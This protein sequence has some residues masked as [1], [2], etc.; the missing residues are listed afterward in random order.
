MKLG[1]PDVVVGTPVYEDLAKDEVFV[2][3][4]FNYDMNAASDATGLE[5][6]DPSLAV[7]S[8][9]EE[10]DINTIVR[11]FNL[12]GQLPQNVVMPQYGDFEGVFDFQ[13]AMNLLIDAEKSFMRFPAEVRK[14]FDNDPAK[15]VDFVSDERNRDE[16]RKLGFL[17]P[18]APPDELL[19]AVRAL[20]P[21][22]DQPPAKS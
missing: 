18:E 12:T 3:T 1:E 15:M 2:R 7:Q 10:S 21:A 13:S 19:E 22:A 8:A 6:G 9:V 14:R 20:K 11:R 4:P 5:C 16:A 17:M